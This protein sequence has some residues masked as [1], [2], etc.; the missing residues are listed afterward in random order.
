MNK[1]FRQAFTLIELLVVIAIIGIL[2]GLIVVAMGGMTDKANIAKAQVFSNSLRNTMML[3]LVSEWRL[4]QVGVP[5]TDQISDSWNG[6]NPGTLKEVSYAS[7]CDATHCPQLKT[8]DCVSGNCLYFNGNDYVDF[9]AKSNLDITGKITI[10]AWFKTTSLAAANQVIIQKPANDTLVNPYRVYAL[11]IDSTLV[12]RFSLSTGVSG[13]QVAL[14][15][16]TAIQ[17]NKWYYLVGTWNGTTANIYLNGIKDNASGASFAG[18]IGI[19]TSVLKIGNGPINTELFSGYLDEIR[20]YNETM[21]ISQI[22]EQYYIGLNNLLNNGSI[23]KEEY[24]S[25]IKDY[26]SI[27]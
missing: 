21:P 7:A 3:N 5:S 26:A 16:S 14:N 17:A 10:G 20:L 18:P 4:D 19:S 11:M 24:L 15:G 1:L 2:S 23:D 13:S 22:K 6:G 12:P 8:S 9:A 27:N 25:R